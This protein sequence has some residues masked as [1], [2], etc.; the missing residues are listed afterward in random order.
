MNRGMK[1]PSR[2]ATAE[3]IQTARENLEGWVDPA[4]LILMQTEGFDGEIY[5][6]LENLQPIGSYKA[7]PIGNVIRSLSDE[8]QNRG[9]F[10]ASS[11]NA[12]IGVAWA[13]FRLGLSVDVVVP[14]NAPQAK[15]DILT[16]LGAAIHVVTPERWWEVIKSQSFE[17]TDKRFVDAVADQAA[18]AGNAIIGMEIIEQVPDADTIL[19]PFGGGGLTCGIGSALK[20]AGHAASLVACESEMATPLT[21]ALAAG[22]PV[23]VNQTKGFISGIGSESVLPWMWPV[24]QQIVDDTCVVSLRQAANAVVRLVQQHHVIA[25][26]A[27]AVSVAAALKR[28]MGGLDGAAK[29]VC[30]VSG[31]NIDRDDLIGILDGS[32]F[33]VS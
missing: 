25:E 21:A 18:I 9:V 31:G 24:M 19:V 15:L 26:G 32:F 5:L 23:A 4:P 20:A 3:E 11:G 8:E 30:V 33:H 22:K 29:V 10:T 6:K 12:G 14:D 13:A 17:G 28:K 16:R 1:Q 27:G 2:L 7:R